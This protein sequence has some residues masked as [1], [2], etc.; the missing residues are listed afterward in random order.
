MRIIRQDDRLI[1]S[2]ANE[3]METRNE[4]MKNTGRSGGIVSATRSLIGSVWNGVQGLRETKLQRT[5]AISVT[6]Y[7]WVAIDGSLKMAGLEHWRSLAY[8]NNSRYQIR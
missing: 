3:K 1:V 4:W 2:E 5:K 6:P 8:A 7:D